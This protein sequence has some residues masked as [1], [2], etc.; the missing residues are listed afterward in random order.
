MKSVANA[1]RKAEVL[2]AAAIWSVVGVYTSNT[3]NVYHL[4]FWTFRHLPVPCTERPLS[5]SVGGRFSCLVVYP[6]L[7]TTESRHHEINAVSL[8]VVGHLG[9][10]QMAVGHLRPAA[11]WGRPK[12]PTNPLVGHLG[13]GS[14]VHPGLKWP[15]DLKV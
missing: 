3:W 9:P 15:T 1:N 2:T 12:W 11:I 14:E 7:D 8:N 13:L 5:D 6:S 10:P 4:Q